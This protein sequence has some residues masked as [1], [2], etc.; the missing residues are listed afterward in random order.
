MKSFS[1]LSLTSP[2]SATYQLICA[3]QAGL[4]QTWAKAGFVRP[5]QAWSPRRSPPAPT[6]NTSLVRWP[7][8]QV[9]EHWSWYETCVKQRFQIHSFK[10][11]TAIA[12]DIYFINPSLAQQCLIYQDLFCKILTTPKL[13][14]WY[15]AA[16][17]CMLQACWLC[18]LCKRCE[19]Q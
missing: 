16:H 19:M 5:A 11:L 4:R 7:S 8:P 6:Q 15:L 2:N 17:G 9:T 12:R 1:I 3:W 18:G 13:E 14:T 10:L